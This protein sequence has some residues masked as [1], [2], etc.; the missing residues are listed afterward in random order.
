MS[1]GLDR[2]RHDAV[3]LQHFVCGDVAQ[4][5]RAFGSYPKGRRFDPHRRYHV[6]HGVRTKTFLV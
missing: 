2:H 6:V 3:I 4:L 1:K 5:V